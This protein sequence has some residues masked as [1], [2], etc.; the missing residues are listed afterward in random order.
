MFNNFDIGGYLIWRLYPQEKVF[1][2][3]RPEAYSV[4][5]FSET[6]KPMQE[7][8][9]KWLEFSEKYSIN[10]IFFGHTDNTPWGQSFLNDIVKNQDWKI[11][12]I[13]EDAIIFVK[14]NKKNS[15]I[16]SEFSI[17]NKN[18]VDKITGHIKSSNKNKVD[19]NLTLSRVLYKIDWLEPSAYFSDEVIKIDPKNPYAYLYKGL[20]HIYYTDK[21]NQQLAEENIKKAIDLGLKESQ[22]YFI[23]GIVYMNLGRLESAEASFKEAIRLDEN[24]TQAKEF[25]TKY[26]NE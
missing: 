11:V 4:K 3:N 8:K 5:F 15:N 25:L 7:N 9:E 1:V 18:T 20:V 12:Y 26:F 10:F 16:V 24:N 21:Q 13:N 23:L 19:L 14:N 2:D 17:T 22:Y 6:Y